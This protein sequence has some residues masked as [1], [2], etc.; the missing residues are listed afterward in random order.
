MKFKQL[1]SGAFKHINTLIFLWGFIFDIFI[2]P[3]IKGIEAKIIGLAYILMVAVFIYFREWVVSRNTAS[4]WEGKLFSF[5]SFVIS[6]FSGSALSFVFVYSMRSAELT[7]S[8]PILFMLLF[9]MF[10]NEFVMTHSFRFS[11]DVG[12]LFVATLFYIIF[13]MPEILKEQNDNV[14]LVSIFVTIII[15]FI[16]AQILR[17]LS[18][19]ANAEAPKTFALAIGIPMIVSMFYFLNAIPPVPLSIKEIGVYHN[20]EKV[21]NVYKG[22]EEIK[23]GWL[24][25]IETEDFHLTPNDTAVYFFSSIDTPAEITAPVSHIWEYYD[26]ASKKWIEKTHISFEIVGGREEGYRTY[27]K[28]GN[29]EAGLWRVTVMIGNNRVVGRKKFNVIKSPEGGLK[30]EDVS[31]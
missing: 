2:L 7:S 15:S 31:L 11:L 25:K 19:T 28:K 14:F 17:K 8:W 30:L 23:S 13:H 27:S 5:A 24:S 6:F 18:H 16:Y 22:K 9:I 1:F 3:D 12:V 26:E 21:G 4:E 20:M 29:V 10:I